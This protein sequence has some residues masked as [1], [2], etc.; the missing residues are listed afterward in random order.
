[1][2]LH[3]ATMT[4]MQCL[5]DSCHICLVDVFSEKHVDIH[6]FVGLLIVVGMAITR[7]C[8]QIGQDDLHYPCMPYHLRWQ[9]R[10]SL[11]KESR[12][13]ELSVKNQERIKCA[14]LS[15]A[16]FTAKPVKTKHPQQ[17]APKRCLLHHA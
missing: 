4:L 8:G 16:N 11:A 15:E 9:F 2:L 10:V 3:V 5:S 12:N 6:N 14:E 13:W 7:S 17:S 1:M